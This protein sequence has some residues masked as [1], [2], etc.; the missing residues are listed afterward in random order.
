MPRSTC[1]SKQ[2]F[3]LVTTTV[4][5]KTNFHWECTHQGCGFK[6]KGKNY[7]A[8]YGRIHLSGDN[9]LRSGLVS[10]V[11][12]KA[13]TPVQQMFAA[14]VRNLQAKKDQSTKKRQHEEQMANV[15]TQGATPFKRQATIIGMIK[16]TES[17][18]VDDAVGE[19]F[20]GCDIAQAVADR[21]LFRVFCKKIQ[22]APTY[23]APSGYRL[24]KVILPRLVEKY[25]KDQASRLKKTTSL[26][27]MI[28]GD[29][30]TILGTKLINA[31]V[32]DYH[33]GVM[34]VSLKDCTGRMQDGNIVDA[35]FIGAHLIE[36]IEAVGPETVFLVSIDGGRDW[37]AC[38]ATVTEKFPWLSFIHCVSHEGSLIVKDIFE[39]EEIAGL[40]EQALNVQ[41]WFSTTKVQALLQ[42]Q[43]KHEFKHELHFVWPAETRFAGKLLQ[44]KRLLRL[45]RA[46]RATIRSAE[47]IEYNFSDDTVDNI[48]LG[49]A[50]WK[51]CE[52][53]E[54]TAAPLLLLV[55]LGDCEAGTLSKLFPTVCNFYYYLLISANFSLPVLV[56][57]LIYIYIF[58]YIYAL[59]HP[60]SYI[61][62]HCNI[63]SRSLIVGGVGGN[64]L[65]QIR[66]G[67]WRWLAGGEDLPEVDRSQARTR[68]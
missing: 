49:D 30:A 8:A 3:R 14:L 65:R 43:C 7:R 15:T 51:L 24:K 68:F 62:V 66:R 32:Q 55:R 35:A 23:K 27:R 36:A 2:H 17:D 19:M 53:V 12:E 29:G 1:P 13:P 20:F 5:E 48:V 16:A 60:F 38:E 67:W 42:V 59:Q 61:C 21:K 6:I 33:N 41:H 54:K 64:V 46:L 37:S 11:C 10:I 39:I 63:H 25:R 18:E 26:G 52:K 4:E 57:M 31:M 40:L 28:S 44:I 58:E 22:M 50:F 56:L 47:Y 34:L 45:K 9:K